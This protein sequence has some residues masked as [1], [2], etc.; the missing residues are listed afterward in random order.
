MQRSL[1]DQLRLQIHRAPSLLD[2]LRL[3]DW[4]STG[5]VRVVKVVVEELVLAKLIRRLSVKD[6]SRGVGLVAHGLKLA[7]LLGDDVVLGG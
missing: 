6:A 5:R 1:S 3:H 4:P 7:V 2:Y